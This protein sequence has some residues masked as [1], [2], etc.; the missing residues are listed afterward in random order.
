[1]APTGGSVGAFELRDKLVTVGPG[2]EGVQVLVNIVFNHV[3]HLYLLALRFQVGQF[4]FEL[5]LEVEIVHQRV[6]NLF[7]FKKL[8]VSL[9]TKLF[10]VSSIVLFKGH[11]T[12]LFREG[13][14]LLMNRFFGLEV[15]EDVI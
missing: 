4:V 5:A 8:D 14:L 13:L 1:M 12:H 6:L 10:K 2:V 9:F 15:D 11:N 7:W 3:V